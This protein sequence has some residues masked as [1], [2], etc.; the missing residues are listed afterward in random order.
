MCLIIASPK[1]A[2]PDSNLLL[3]AAIDNPDGYGIVWYDNGLKVRKGLDTLDSLDALKAIP[4]GAPYVLHYRWT[5]HGKNNTDNCHP[6]K[7]GGWGYMAHNG[8][9][10]IPTERNTGM[11]DTWHFAQYWVKPYLRQNPS[12]KQLLKMCEQ[13]IGHGNKLAFLT[14]R[15]DVLI[16]NES[17][18]FWEDNIWYSNAGSH[19]EL[20]NERNKKRKGKH[21]RYP[22][23]CGA[24]RYVYPNAFGFDPI[25]DGN[26]GDAWETE[27]IAQATTFTQTPN[28]IPKTA[29]IGEPDIAFKGDGIECDFCGHYTEKLWFDANTKSYLCESC[30]EELALT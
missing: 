30:A 7:L 2:R 14:H 27:V 6:F 3:Q 19:W 15:G 4:D 20:E 13:F 17:Y 8:V 10:Q 28:I 16:A 26:I 21:D 1:G 12:Y 24:Y 11:S 23:V 9:L 18:G 5:T 25:L 29:D 22:T